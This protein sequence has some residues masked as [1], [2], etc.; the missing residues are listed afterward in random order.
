MKKKRFFHLSM[1]IGFLFT[2]LFCCF[3]VSADAVEGSPGQTVSGE[4]AVIINTDT[5]SSQNTGTL[6]FDD[7]TDTVSSYLSTGSSA[8]NL[9][10]SQILKKASDTSDYNVLSSSALSAAATQSAATSY[11]IGQEKYIY[12]SNSTGKTYVCIGIG[13]HC[14]IWMDKD[15]KAS[16]DAAGK[17]SS[18]A[19]DMAGVYDGQPYRILNTLAGG[20]IPYEDNSG[21]ISILLETLSS[22]SGMYMYDTGITAIHINTPSAS[23]YVSGEMSKRNGLLVHEGQHALLW[24]KTRFSNTGRY[25]WLNEGLAVTAMDYLWGGIDS[26]GWLNGIAGS[27]A[28]RSGSSLI[29]QTYRDDTAQDY[30]MPYLFMRYVIDRMAG[31]YK[32]MDVLPKFYQIDAST[33]TCEEY[34]TQVT[35]IPFK[36]LMADFY[37]AIAAGDLYGN[38]SFSGDRIAAG[39]AATFPVF[40]GNSNQNYTLPAASAVIIK[41]KNGKF[42]VPANGSSSIIYRIVGNRTTSAAPSEGS[43]T[44]SDPYKITSLDDLNLISDH[45]GAYYS[46]TKDIQTNGNI[47]FSVNYFSGH[48]DGNSHTI[49]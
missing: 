34:L 12:R 15:M 42:T 7:G 29:Y 49:Y 39:K 31:S 3:S 40:S 43:G 46:L 13:E 16:Y 4:Y 9:P 10:A 41:L 37:T 35:G 33:L 19:K 25:M 14:Y 1:G 47:N 27:T 32:P 21:K 30:G 24:L 28:I 11:Y 38:Y 22:A 18:I 17:T 26:S 23:A 48:L 2:G 20:N 44:A 36:T 45:P 5:S 8:A 6:V